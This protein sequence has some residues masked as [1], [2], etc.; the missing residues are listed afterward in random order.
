MIKIVKKVEPKSLTAYKKQPDATFNGMPALVKNDLRQQLLEEQGYLCAYCMTRIPNDRC[1]PNNEFKMKI[2]H[3][4]CQ[5]NYP[6]DQL[7]YKN[8]LAVCCGNEG[9]SFDQHCDTRK[10]NSDLKYNPANPADEVEDKIEY[11]SFDGSIFSKDRE[12]NEQLSLVLNLNH[13]RFKRNRKSVLDSVQAVLNHRP[14]KRTLKEIEGY[15]ANWKKTGINGELKEYC[16]IAIY[17]LYK[18]LHKSE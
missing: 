3:W 13:A 11:Y 8:L 2:E 4:H 10:G 16:G 12:F 18:K 5:S 17:Y 15:I 6:E 7:N 9:Q 14:G 1:P